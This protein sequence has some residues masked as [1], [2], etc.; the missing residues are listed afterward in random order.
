[1]DIDDLLRKVRGDG[2]LDRIS[3]AMGVKADIDELCDA[4]I[5]RVVQEARAAGHSWS[6]I[7][8]AMGVTKQAA[9]QRHGRG[10]PHRERSPWRM[11]YRWTARAKT[12]VRE[13][14]EAA[15]RAGVDEI[16]TEHL[17][18]GIL[19]V[20]E[21]LA[22][23]IV[24]RAGLTREHVLADAEPQ[25]P[26]RRRRGHVRMDEDAQRAIVAAHHHALRLGHDY[27]GTEHQLLG[28]FDV[29]E[30]PGAR[31]LLAVGLTEAEVERQVVAALQGAA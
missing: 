21:G 20:P 4:L 25:A 24:A 6:E 14:H 19:A 15:L 8:T 22:G 13:A 26:T 29:P 31:A 2:P 12:V 23:R 11:G 16:G 18:L 10:R 28:L 17:L 1:M 9:Q 27:V 3:S 5:D 30:S 7:G